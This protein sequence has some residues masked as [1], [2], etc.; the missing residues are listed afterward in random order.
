MKC[1][2]T[3]CREKLITRQIQV[4]RDIDWE[5]KSTLY[6]FGSTEPSSGP[7]TDDISDVKSMMGVWKCK[8]LGE[9]LYNNKKLAV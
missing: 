5:V 6:R 3:I 4:E 2:P 1:N 9:N 8:N 7:L